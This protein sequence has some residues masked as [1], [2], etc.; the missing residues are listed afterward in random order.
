MVAAV[1]LSLTIN[2]S[3]IGFL[4]LFSVSPEFRPVNWLAG[5]GTWWATLAT[6]WWAVTR[7][8]TGRWRSPPSS[9]RTTRSFSA[10]WGLPT[11][12]SP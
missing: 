11:G 4:V 6:A 9:W 1:F 5:A 10:K 12:S 7:R 2:N 3:Q 8:R